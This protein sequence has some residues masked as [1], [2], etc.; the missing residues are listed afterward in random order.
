MFR[1]LL[2][3][4][5]VSIG[6]VNPDRHRGFLLRLLK[7]HSETALRLTDLNSEAMILVKI[8]ITGCFLPYNVQNFARIVR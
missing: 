1:K 7:A 8:T 3:H 4:P 2:K 5:N 6:V